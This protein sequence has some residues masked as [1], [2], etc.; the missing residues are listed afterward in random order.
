[1]M[2]KPISKLFAEKLRQI[3]QST[4]FIVARES[5]STIRLKNKSWGSMA[6]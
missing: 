2:Y 6:K 1:M 4:Y 5:Q 3:L